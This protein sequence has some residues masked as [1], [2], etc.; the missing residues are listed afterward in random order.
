MAGELAAGSLVELSGLPEEVAGKEL[1]LGGDDEGRQLR[2]N[3]W[4]GQVL[5]YQQDGRV[6]VDTFQGL[7]V[8]VAAENLKT[9][10]PA[11]PEMGGFHV[12][13]PP[14]GMAD[15]GRSILLCQAA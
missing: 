7:R 10:S 14:E 13:W 12:A 4:Q 6:V 15:L 9:F 11:H 5:Q 3:G 8:V 2:P 1:L